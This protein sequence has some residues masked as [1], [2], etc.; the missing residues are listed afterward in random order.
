MAAFQQSAESQQWS[1]P[2]GESTSRSGESEPVLSLLVSS[3]R[4]RG[5]SPSNV[6]QLGTQMGKLQRYVICSF[7]VGSNGERLVAK[8]SPP[9]DRRAAN[10]LR[11]EGAIHAEVRR[12]LVPVHPRLGVPALRD[13]FETNGMITLVSEFIEGTSEDG[14][15]P[16]TALRRH[17]ADIDAL[18]SVHVPEDTCLLRLQGRDYVRSARIHARYLARAGFWI[19]LRPLRAS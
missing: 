11:Q 2:G 19:G 6:K 3:L 8:G 12:L 15:H 17:V 18:Q 16:L 14:L 9:D 7:S 5:Y 10:R 1:R 13:V 4:G